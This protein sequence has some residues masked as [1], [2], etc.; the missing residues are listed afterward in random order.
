M[1]TCFWI[2]LLRCIHQR[3]EWM[4]RRLR[5]S[6]LM[7]P[8]RILWESVKGEYNY[9]THHSHL[10][11]PRFHLFGLALSRC[12]LRCLCCFSNKGCYVQNQSHWVYLY[13]MR[14]STFTTGD[15]ETLLSLR[16]DMKPFHAFPCHCVCVCVCL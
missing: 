10:A 1:S 6:S 4:A 11:S 16:P 9:F 12:G 13:L 5:G 3:E 14:P 8:S 2:I 15:E 7:F